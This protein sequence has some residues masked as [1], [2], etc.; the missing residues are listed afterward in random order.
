MDS[1]WRTR[2]LAAAAV[3][4]AVAIGFAGV[5]LLGDGEPVAAPSPSP[6]PSPS[7]TAP[8]ELKPFSVTLQKAVDQAMDNGNLY[9]RPPDLRD[10]LVERS[11]RDATAVVERYLNTVFV[12]PK[13]RGKDVVLKQLLTERARATLKRS[14]RA[15]LGIGAPPIVGASR[16]RASARVIVAHD[17]PRVMTMTIKFYVSMNAITEA[18]RESSVRQ[19][20]VF[21]LVP[22]GKQWRVDMLDV[23][24][25]PP[26]R[27]RPPAPPPAPA[28][29][30]ATEVTPS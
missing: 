5:R 30:G 15:A 26:Q 4:V 29:D 7:P 24:L 16:Q 27:G 23:R 19:E 2:L 12:D 17:G 21:V 11:A 9:V 10:V 14:D 3:V 13:S 22:A 20:G 28:S 1:T 25:V 6:S 8:A 18:G